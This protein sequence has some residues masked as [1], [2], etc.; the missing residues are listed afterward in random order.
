MRPNPNQTHLDD[1]AIA[2]DI[3]GGSKFMAEAYA[4][5]ALDSSSPQLRQAFASIYMDNLAHN[6]R[7]FRLMQQR[8]WYS[9][10]QADQQQINQLQSKFSMSGQEQYGFRAQRGQ[11]EPQY[12]GQQQ[13]G[14]QGQHNM[15]RY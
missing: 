11:Y 7:I 12:G 5:S 1:R 13:S 8:G 2:N 9:V 4:K 14:W 6:E 3:L 10:E 15:Q